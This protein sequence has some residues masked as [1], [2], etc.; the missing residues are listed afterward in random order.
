MWIY[1]LVIRVFAIGALSACPISLAH[2]QTVRP[3]QIAP[4]GLS[5]AIEVFSEQSGLQVA[6]PGDGLAGLRTGGVR[7]TFEARS[8]L[9]QLISGTGLR[10]RFTGVSSVLLVKQDPVPSAAD[11][12]VVLSPIT[13]LGQNFG[14]DRSDAP[15][16]IKSFSS[17][18]IEQRNINQVTDVLDQ[19]PNVNVVNA[20]TPAFFQV[21]IRGISDF[22]NVDSTGPTTGIF[23]DGTLLNSNVS[24]GSN[25]LLIDTESVEVLL[26]P[27]GRFQRSTTAGAINITTKKPTD[28]F[29]AS[30]RGEIGSFPDG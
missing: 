7:G 13:V 20:A 21:A 9:D 19:T 6:A 12:E 22:G 11:G 8:A 29:E 3:F 16:S 18:E 28:E 23:V 30:F 17:D 27:Q 15:A 24:F 2:A 4:Q 25:P 10:Y 14:L 5:S 26:G 1:Q